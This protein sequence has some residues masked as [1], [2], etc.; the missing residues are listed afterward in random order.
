[1]TRQKISGI[2]ATS[3]GLFAAA[4]V[5]LAFEEIVGA[6]IAGAFGSSLLAVCLVHR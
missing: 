4:I 2:L 1:M 5:F 6:C 3:C